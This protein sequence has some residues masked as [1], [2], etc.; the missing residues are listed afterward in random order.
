MY[1]V[2]S[3][4]IATFVLSQLISCQIPV[5][6]HNSDSNS[7]ITCPVTILAS[8]TGIIKSPGFLLQENYATLSN[9]TNCTWILNAPI[10]TIIEIHTEFIEIE[11]AMPE[12]YFD[13]LEFRESDGATISGKVCGKSNVP[14]YRS[15]TNSVDIDFKTD[16]SNNVNGF[17]LKY[18][19]LDKSEAENTNSET[20]TPNLNCTFDY[21]FVYCPGWIVNEG[22]DKSSS[23][24]WNLHAGETPSYDTGPKTEHTSKTKRGMYLYAEASYPAIT[25][26]EAVLKSPVVK[27]QNPKKAHCFELWYHK[28]S[29]DSLIV[30]NLFDETQKT[31][32]VNSKTAKN[33][34]NWSLLKLE[35]PRNSVDKVQIEIKAVRGGNPL[36]DIAIDDIEFYEGECKFFDYT[37]RP[38][39]STSSYIYS[40]VG[41]VE[42]SDDD[43]YRS[44]CEIRCHLGYHNYGDSPIVC[45]R[46]GWAGIENRELIWP[47]PYCDYLE[48]RQ[49]VWDKSVMEIECSK[50]YVFTSECAFECI[51]PYQ[52]VGEPL[53]TCGSDYNWSP[54]NELPKCKVCCQ[55]EV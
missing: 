20:Q 48:C 24:K 28:T 17:Q 9:T 29:G 52:L 38:H 8:N 42:C 18:T 55:S 30:K 13:Y 10:N 25:G 6:T 23:Y 51:K 33:W 1:Q 46:H 26:D 16:Y 35:I 34:N 7:E 5:D 47:P 14:V 31:E 37:C 12:C 32:A 49:F 50:D 54:N 41:D 15:T 43:N 40:N 45:E 39:Y 19:V 21:G 36:N 11:G 22:I 44:V 53:A 3:K 4:I 2:R 27:L